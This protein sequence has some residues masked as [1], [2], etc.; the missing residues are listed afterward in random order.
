MSN[1]VVCEIERYATHDG[2]G[3]RTVVFLK[4]CP[5]KCLWCANPETQRKENELYYNT[6][7]CI[8]CKRCINSCEK[9]AL[10]FE[11]EKVIVDKNK[12]NSCGECVKACPMEALNLVGKNSTVDEVF[13]EVMKDTIFYQQSGGGITISGGE[14]LMHRDFAVKLLKMCKENY[15]NTA[16]ETSGFGDFNVLKEISVYCD[17]IMFDIKH[18][19]GKVHKKLT[20]VD[21]A[22]ILDNL[23]RL[24]EIHKNIIIRMPLIT[25]FNESEENIINTVKIAKEN[26]I[27][28]IHLLPYHS[29]GK[30]KYKQLGR[31]YELS[32]LKEPEEEKVNSL[33]TIIEKDNIKCKIGG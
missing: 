12:C 23:K 6:N 31:D 32:H 11:D 19:D 4:G 27:K 5:L 13:N 9:A 20:E 22:I 1:T 2:P 18:T 15:I 25:G 30:D 7:K 21:N 33:K 24:S 16:I 10:Q 3:I 17:L 26:N 29:L 28:E 14:V 8:A